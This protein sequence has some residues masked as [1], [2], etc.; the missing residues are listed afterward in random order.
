MKPKAHI[1]HY[2]KE[3]INRLKSILQKYKVIAIADMTNM[4]SHQLQKL[5]SNIKDSV[6]ITMSKGRL[7]KIIFEDLKDKIKGLNKLEPLIRGMPALLLTNDNPFKLSK[8]L[9]K[10]KSAAPAKAGQLAPNDIMVPAG[11]TPFPPGP[12]MGELGQIG[13]KATVVEGKVAVKDDTIVVKEGKPISAQVANILTRLGIEPM[14]I[15]INLLAALENGTLFTKD[16]L[17]IDESVYVN[18]LKLAYKNSFNLAFNI[19]YTT[20]QNIK[21]LIKKAY[22]DSTALADSRKILTSENVKKEL[23]KANLEAESLKSKLN[24]PE[25][26]FKKEE[27]EIPLMVVGTSRGMFHERPETID[28]VPDP[29]PVSRDDTDEK[30]AQEVLRKLQDEKISKMPPV[31]KQDKKFEKDE[32]AAQDI[33]K[34]LQDEKIEKAEKEARKPR[35]F[36]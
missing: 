3:E 15:G 34:K 22:L 26:F 30:V 5:R 9:R 36:V 10:S 23:A 32:K 18:N 33:L 2:K 24:L 6:L 12:I 25:S 4:P 14:E 29:R 35:G 16:I 1:A 28:F 11:P 17:N 31:K 19:V 20:K 13:I 21:L 7:I 8:T 27:E